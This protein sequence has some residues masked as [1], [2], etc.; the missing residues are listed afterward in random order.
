MVSG[1][2]F[3]LEIRGYLYL[4]RFHPMRNNR[5]VLDLEIVGMGEGGKKGLKMWARA[6]LCAAA[7]GLSLIHI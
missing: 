2:E 3:Q 6:I 4:T 5:S 7:F 1:P